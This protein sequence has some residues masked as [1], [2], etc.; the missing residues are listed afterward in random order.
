MTFSR[1]AVLAAGA[2][3]TLALTA[4]CLDVV[5]GNGPLEFDAGRVAP[6][7]DAVAT[8]GYQESDVSDET[9]ERTVELPGG[10]ERE[11]RATIWQSTYTKAVDYAGQTREG[12]A[13]AGVSIPGMQVAGRSLNPL[14]ELSNTE[15]LE[16]FLGQLPSD[17]GELSDLT[18]EDSFGLEILGDG[19]TVD[20]FVGT[21]DLEGETIEIELKLTSFD[22]EGDL[23]VLL[24]TYP[25]LLT[26]ESANVEQ[27]MESA[28]HPIS[29]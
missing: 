12:A 22:H 6:T 1:R 15:L 23:L 18:H 10:V 5:L 28:E 11:A 21:S 26:A 4:G 9:I 7:D 29:S 17:H 8:A 14:G 19:R 3:G 25:K 16:R 13:F 27:L 24:G 2:T 20:L